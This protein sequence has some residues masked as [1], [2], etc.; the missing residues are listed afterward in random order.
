MRRGGALAAE[1]V[2][3]CDEPGAEQ[4]LPQTIH[5]DSRGQRVLGRR[6]PARKTQAVARGVWW[7]RHDAG[8]RVARYLRPWRVVRATQEH[9]RRPRL[10][11]LGHRHDLR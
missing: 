9:V 3:S 11:G 1:V 10:I 5:G 2:W 7:K 6:Q 4:P 8:G